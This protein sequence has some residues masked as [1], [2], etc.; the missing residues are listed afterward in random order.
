[1]SGIVTENSCDTRFSIGR[2]AGARSVY[3]LAM[4]NAFKT[5]AL[6]GKYKSPEIAKLYTKWLESPIPPKGL[7]LKLPMSATMKKAFANPSDSGDP[8]KY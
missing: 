7:S 6:I 8:A 2:R 3:N 5:I 4:A 1:M